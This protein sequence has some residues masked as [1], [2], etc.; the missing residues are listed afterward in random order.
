MKHIKTKNKT[1]PLKGGRGTDRFVTELPV[2]IGGIQGVTRNISATGIYFETEMAQEPGSR[3]NFTVE[4]HVR[5]EKL[6][7]VCEGEV[8]RVGCYDGVFGMATKVLSSFFPTLR[9]SLAS[10]QALWLACIKI[11]LN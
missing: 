7:L 5:G 2:D 3:V 8:V 10:I 11:S 4:V 1:P 6:K 9:K